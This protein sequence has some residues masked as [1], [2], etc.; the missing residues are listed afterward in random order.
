M[1]RSLRSDGHSGKRGP[2]KSLQL[3]PG[4]GRHS[5]FQSPKLNPFPLGPLQIAAH[6]KWEQNGCI[7]LF[8]RTLKMELVDLPETHPGNKKEF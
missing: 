4:Q 8:P 3:A 2:R 5:S 6:R 7:C 1:Y